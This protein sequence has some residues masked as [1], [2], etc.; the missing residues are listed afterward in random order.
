MKDKEE[1]EVK[2]TSDQVKS[3]EIEEIG[4][5]V[6]SNIPSS[7]LQNPEGK[8]Q[9]Q[10]SEAT[11][12]QI[13]KPKAEI[14]EKV[15]QEPEK[16]NEGQSIQTEKKPDHKMEVEKT[17]PG[18]PEIKKSPEE[19][20]AE[21]EAKKAE[22]AAKKANAK[23]NQTK[24]DPVEEITKETEKLSVK[25]EN[26]KSKE[27]IL[28]ER[29]AKKAEKAARR[30]A[31]NDNKPKVEVKIEPKKTE[32][33]GKSKAELKAERRAKQEA[34]RAAKAAGD[35]KKKGQK[36]IQG[37]MQQKSQRVPDDIQADR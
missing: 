30:A 8:G 22:K 5:E 33:G 13:I 16:A 34:Q 12:N 3:T 20:K 36:D 1:S 15:N 31:V 10:Q 7:K 27:E 32:E 19:I 24:K 26:K 4:Q 18:K 23:Q 2:I 9:I 11:D 14:S 6:L 29:E 21:R 28:A 25:E 35:E 37:K 17:K